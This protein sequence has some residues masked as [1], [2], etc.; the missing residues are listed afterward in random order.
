[1]CYFLIAVQD[2]Q[3]CNLQSKHNSLQFLHLSLTK[4]L[5]KLNEF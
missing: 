1:M 4:Q 2:S 5:V 3:K